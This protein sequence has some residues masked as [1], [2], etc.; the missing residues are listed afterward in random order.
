MYSMASLCAGRCSLE[1]VRT[2]ASVLASSRAKIESKKRAC[3]A[4]PGSLASAANG[5]FC[6]GGRPA[7]KRAVSSGVAVSALRAGAMASVRTT[8]NSAAAISLGTVES[9]GLEGY[10]TI[11]IGRRHIREVSE[12]IVDHKPHR[13]QPQAAKRLQRPSHDKIVHYEQGQREENQGR[14]RVTPGAVW[15]HQFRVRDAHFDQAQDREKRA[16]RQAEL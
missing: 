9:I 7:R 8:A 12:R 11:G 2:F 13:H 3:C 15:P 6:A 10:C 14:D 5:E 16:E 4:Q 1:N